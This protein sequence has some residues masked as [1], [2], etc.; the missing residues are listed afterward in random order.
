MPKSSLVIV[1]LLFCV[2]AC[3]NKQPKVQNPQEL[4]G[5]LQS[6]FQESARDAIEISNKAIEA[7]PQSPEAFF[8]RAQAKIETGN[9]RSAKS[10]LEKAAALFKQQNNQIG[11]EMVQQIY[12]Q[13][14]S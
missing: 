3:S 12:S 1:L 14:K 2:S 8:N 13:L 5:Y 6:G 7:N 11:Y 9:I 10:D 4:S